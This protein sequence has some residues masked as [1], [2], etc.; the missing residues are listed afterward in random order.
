MPDLLVKKSDGTYREVTETEWLALTGS[1]AQLPATLGPHPG[2]GSVSVVPATDAAWGGSGTLTDRSGTITLGGTSQQAA[3]ANA[4]RR[5]LLIQNVSTGDLW[6]NFGTAAVVGQ[7]SILI[8][9]N[10]AYEP[11]FIPTGTVNII[12]AT[13]AQAFAMKEA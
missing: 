11:V 2:A 9:A 10:G 8:K 7:P 3:A 6:V 12:G 13:T 1:A 5:Y 4:S